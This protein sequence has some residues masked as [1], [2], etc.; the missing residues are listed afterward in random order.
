MDLL[1]ENVRDRA[2][3][4]R[5][6]LGHFCQLAEEGIVQRCKEPVEVRGVGVLREVRTSPQIITVGAQ[7]P[8][9]DAACQTET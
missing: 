3:R 8:V 5:S 6:Q 2:A 1:Q 9:L 4:T 7:P